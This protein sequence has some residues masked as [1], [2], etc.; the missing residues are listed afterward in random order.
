MDAGND[1]LPG[2]R[3]TSIAGTTL[4]VKLP[5][6]TVM[7]ASTTAA[8]SSWKAM[9]IFAIV[10]ALAGSKETYG[11]VTNT[12]PQCGDVSSRVAGTGPAEAL[13][14]MVRAERLA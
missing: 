3:K 6:S 13:V 12:L 2:C 4:P 1:K 14:E 7:L 8:M 5:I 11:V 9:E 10:P